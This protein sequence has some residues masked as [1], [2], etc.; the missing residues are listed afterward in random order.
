MI[1]IITDSTSD[2][3]KKRREEISVDA[4]PLEIH[5]GQETF[6]DGIDITNEQFFK[7][8]AEAEELPTT[9]QVNP[10]EF[11]E[12]FKKYADLG[13]EIVCITISSHLS[14]TY[15]SAVAALEMVPS[16]KIRLIDSQ[17]ATFGL[18]LLVEEAAK[19]RDKGASAEAIEAEIRRLIG[20]VRLIAA[21]DTLKYLKM[22]GRISGAS[23]AVGNLLGIKPII[24]IIEGKVEAIGKARGKNAA[25]KEILANYAKDPADESYFVAFGHASAPDMLEEFIDA[26]SSV[27]DVKKALKSEIGS[28]VGTHAGPGAAGI[29]YIAK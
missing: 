15:Q 21:V 24:S 28:T 13:D 7:K 10:Y 19:L 26:F 2:I 22:G 3:S 14:G 25:L 4:L 29:A 1:R 20:K 27:L 5:F 11:A 6:R 9:S 8:L 23:A 17:N 16:A 12:I 18:G